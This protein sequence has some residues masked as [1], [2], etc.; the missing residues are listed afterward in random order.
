MLESKEFNAFYNN[1]IEDIKSKSHREITV[2][3]R[4]RNE[5]LRHSVRRLN[6]NNQSQ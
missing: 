5:N 3:V 4:L 2:K 1:L 6:Y